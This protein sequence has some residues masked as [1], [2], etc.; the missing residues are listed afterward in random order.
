MKKFISTG[1][2]YLLFAVLYLI[3]TLSCLLSGNILLCISTI[4]MS[5]IAI[6]MYRREKRNKK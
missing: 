3:I 4:L 2:I 5:A 1:Q 6:L